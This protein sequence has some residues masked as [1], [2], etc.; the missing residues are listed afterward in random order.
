MADHRRFLDADH[1]MFRR[2]WVRWLTVALPAAWTVFEAAS[3]NWFWAVLFGAA[4]A[5][6]FWVLI[7]RGPTGG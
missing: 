5:Y 1:P 4:A 3:G 6:A 2:A 7:V